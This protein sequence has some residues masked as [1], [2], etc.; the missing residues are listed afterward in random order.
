M[1]GSPL[2]FSPELSKNE[3]Y[4]NKT[5]IWSLGCVIFEICT[6]EVKKLSILE[7]FQCF[8]R[9]ADWTVQAHPDKRPEKHPFFILPWPQQ[10]HQK[11]V[12]K[13]SKEKTHCK[14]TPSRPYTCSINDQLLLSGKFKR[15]IRTE[16]C[17]EANP[18]WLLYRK[19]S[20][21]CPVAHEAV[22][23]GSEK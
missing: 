13:G 15:W 17:G 9:R 5:D 11:D 14:I 8:K 16:S 23:G 4:T 10:A 3:K 2:Y 6:L 22:L 21:C 12:D 20:E 19:S 7:T 1:A 18:Y